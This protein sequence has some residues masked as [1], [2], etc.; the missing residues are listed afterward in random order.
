[1]SHDPTKVEPR[2]ICSSGFWREGQVNQTEYMIRVECTWGQ[3]RQI[4]ERWAQLQFQH[5]QDIRGL[6]ASHESRMRLFK[7]YPLEMIP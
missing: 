4:M 6:K 7:K 5:D 1:M 2:I 3:A